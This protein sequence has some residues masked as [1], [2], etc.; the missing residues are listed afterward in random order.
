VSGGCVAD[1][2]EGMQRT[3][4]EKAFQCLADGYS[5]GYGSIG[6]S[7]D[8]CAVSDNIEFMQAFYAQFGGPAP[9]QEYR[10]QNMHLDRFQG[11]DD[12]LFKGTCADLEPNGPL[13]SDGGYCSA[14]YLMGEPT[15]LPDRGCNDTP[16]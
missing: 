1:S 15:S 16:H 6:A 13:L 5:G 7:V 11:C 8:E 14:A 9:A 2:L 10:S 3:W 4:C 12:A